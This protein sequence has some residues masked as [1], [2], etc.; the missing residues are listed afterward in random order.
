MISEK[1]ATLYVKSAISDIMVDDG[2][3]GSFDVASR[4]LTWKIIFKVF[5]KGVRHRPALPAN[6]QS[7]Q[8]RREFRLDSHKFQFQSQLHKALKATFVVSI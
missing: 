1:A 3:Q 5:E 6:I 8:D 4:T 7:T 2:P